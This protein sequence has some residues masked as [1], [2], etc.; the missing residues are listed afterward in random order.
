M[1][2]LNQSKKTQVELQGLYDIDKVK[3]SGALFEDDLELW[4]SSSS[5]DRQTTEKSNTDHTP[6]K[7]SKSP[8]T[9]RSSIFEMF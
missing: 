2:F 7:A 4:T 6:N 5:P 3:K 8:H 9:K 1:H